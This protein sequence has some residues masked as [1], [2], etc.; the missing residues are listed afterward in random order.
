[1]KNK[2]L[3][4]LAYVLVGS[5]F[6][7]GIGVSALEKNSRKLDDTQKEEILDVILK[8]ENIQ[9]N[10]IK[11]LEFDVEK[12]KGKKV[13]KVEFETN[14]KEY[15]IK[16]DAQTNEVIKKEVDDNSKS[17]EKQKVTT[18]NKDKAFEIALAHANVLA[19]EIREL[20]VELDDG[21]YEI[22][23][24]VKTAEYDYEIDA[25]TGKIL[26]VEKEVEEDEEEK[27]TTI[28]K[29]KALEMALAHA[30]VL[31]SEIREL[32]VELDDGVYEISFEVKTT[33]YEYEIDAKTG[34]ILNVEKE[35]DD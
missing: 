15:E 21:V 14:K 23:F 16:I 24:E 35:I 11:D 34:K 9:K 5:L 3:N 32:E 22:S 7:G 26:N 30:K 27:V 28:N 4:V 33:D 25:K 29:D 2:K 8:K 6:A 31:A 19:S 17:T 10:E 13:V 1:M 20:E 18:I 12:E